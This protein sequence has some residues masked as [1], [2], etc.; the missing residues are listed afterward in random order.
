MQ[1]IDQ[2]KP[3]ISRA[4]ATLTTLAVLPRA[5]S[6]RYRVQSLTCAFHP[7]SRMIFGSASIR[8]TS[9][10]NKPG[11]SRNGH[12]TRVYPLAPPRRSATRIV[13]SRER[14]VPRPQNVLNIERACRTAACDAPPSL[15]SNSD[16]RHSLCDD[17]K[18]HHARR[19][20]SPL[21][22]ARCHQ[23]EAAARPQRPIRN[24]IKCNET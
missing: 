19:R 2:M 20:R 18:V 12:V 6:R 15:L 8:S 16:A 11:P 13:V 3:T 7:M 9:L 1:A 10:I 21:R 17:R 14:A 23:A 22:L 24:N 5:R 4:M